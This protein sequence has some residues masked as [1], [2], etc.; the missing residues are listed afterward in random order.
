MGTPRGL[1]GRHKARGCQL[2][3]EGLQHATYQVFLRTIDRNKAL[4]IVQ[5][6]SSPEVGQ[7]VDALPL[8]PDQAHD[9]P[10]F[11]VTVDNA[12]LPQVVHASH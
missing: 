11:D 2:G 9:V 6:P 3:A 4:L 5:L 8:L 7:L 1:F 10:R 12:V